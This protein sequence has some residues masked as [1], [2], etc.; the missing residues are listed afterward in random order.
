[1]GY[2]T[3]N[4]PQDVFYVNAGLTAVSTTQVFLLLSIPYLFGIH[5]GE[6]DARNFGLYYR[7]I[8][9][10]GVALTL[11]VSILGVCLKNAGLTLTVLST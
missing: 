6:T 8:S 10:A 11:P 2:I 4:M 9:I 7:L 5:K 1:M 3:E